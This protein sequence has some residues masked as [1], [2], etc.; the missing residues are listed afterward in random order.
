MLVRRGHAA[1]NP[2]KLPNI[3]PL[4]LSNTGCHC[5]VASASKVSSATYAGQPQSQLVSAVTL[6]SDLPY[7]YV[8][9]SLTIADHPEPH[10]NADKQLVINMAPSTVCRQL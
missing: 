9:S 10:A 7:H 2:S 3:N 8:T 5:T 6:P 4:Y 1:S